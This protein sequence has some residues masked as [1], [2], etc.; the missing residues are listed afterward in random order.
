MN[1]AAETVAYT[2]IVKNSV[3]R[4][5]DDWL[6]D[7]LA[8]E[9]L[10]TYAQVNFITNILDFRR[11]YLRHRGQKSR[12]VYVTPGLDPERQRSNR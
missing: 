5:E 4:N 3:C 12:Y 7:W 10:E 6:I 8:L 9:T 11:R 2:S 1:I